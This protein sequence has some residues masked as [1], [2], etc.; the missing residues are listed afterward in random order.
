M[1]MFEPISKKWEV[2]LLDGI[3][4]RSMYA[5]QQKLGINAGIVKMACE[6]LNYYKTGVSKIDGQRYSFRYFIA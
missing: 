2:A 6:G 1:R 4:F 5:T 3:Y